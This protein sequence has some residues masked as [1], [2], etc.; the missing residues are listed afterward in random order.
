MA[1]NMPSM[2]PPRLLEA[3]GDQ[4]STCAQCSQRE[5]VTTRAWE[6]DGTVEYS[7]KVAPASTSVVA[8]RSNSCSWLCTAVRYSTCAQPPVASLEPCYSL[9]IGMSR[10]SSRYL[11]S[12]R[13]VAAERL[14]LEAP[15]RLAIKLHQPS[16][17]CTAPLGAS[18]EPDITTPIR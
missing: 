4:A 13:Q 10:K 18:L 5:Y 11:T 12:P 8:K 16:R 17:Y 9:N 6:K 7:H 1:S 2:V 15:C 14:A 3:F